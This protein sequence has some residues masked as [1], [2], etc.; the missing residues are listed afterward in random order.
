[1]T[2]TKSQ[3][4]SPATGRVLQVSTGPGGVP[5]YPVE[6]AWV[7]RAGVEGDR[8]RGAHHG[9]PNAAVC[10]YAA[11]AIARVAADGH[12]AFP[13]AYGE[14]LTTEGLEIGLLAPGTQLAIGSGGLVLEISGP[15]APCATLAHYFI[16]GR[17]ARV[18]HT[19]RPEDSRQYALVLAEGPVAPGDAITVIE[20]PPAPSPAPSP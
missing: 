16:D 11:E 1:M 9:G 20:P 5:N 8:H 12:Q 4:S 17:I 15:T 13:G 14:N 6:Q 7:S 2:D 18:S 19:V 3:P 10:L